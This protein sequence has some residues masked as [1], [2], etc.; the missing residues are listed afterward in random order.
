MTKNTSLLYFSFVFKDLLACENACNSF[1]SGR[2]SDATV[3]FTTS[4]SS[5]RPDM[6][7]P[8]RAAR[9]RTIPEWILVVKL[10]Y[11]KLAPFLPAWTLVPDSNYIGRGSV[12]LTH[13]IGLSGRRERFAGKAD[14]GEMP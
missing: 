6:E 11:Q 1:Y 8:Y 2:R 4:L 9:A 5:V 10:F 7:C 14:F 3:I 12:F 13:P